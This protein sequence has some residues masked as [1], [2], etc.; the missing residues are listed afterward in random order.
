MKA[1]NLIAA[2]VVVA[3]CFGLAVFVACRERERRLDDLLTQLWCGNVASRERAELA[4]RRNAE[5]LLPLIE[6]RLS[7]RDSTMRR[8]WIALTQSHAWLGPHLISQEEKHAPAWRACVVLGVQAAPVLDALLNLLVDEPSTQVAIAISAVG[9]AAVRPLT[10]LLKHDRAEVRQMSAMALARLFTAW[11][12]RETRVCEPLDRFG[13][14]LGLISNLADEDTCVRV[15][16][17][18]TLGKMGSGATAA[19]PALQHLLDDTEPLVRSTAQ[20][21]LA[22]ILAASPD[23]QGESTSD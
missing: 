16:A 11:S 14:A 18:Y 17:A 21:A 5:R 15:A 23:H 6:Q 8:Q 2:G 7:A 13:V 22:R 10:R 4:V 19:V 3:A 9:P 12:W 1:Q 20:Q